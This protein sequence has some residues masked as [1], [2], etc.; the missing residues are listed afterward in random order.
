VRLEDNAGLVATVVITLSVLVR[1]S[2]HSAKPPGARTSSGQGD[3]IHPRVNLWP[4]GP[5]SLTRG[6]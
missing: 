5:R 2:C 4:A 1:V 6:G 3:K